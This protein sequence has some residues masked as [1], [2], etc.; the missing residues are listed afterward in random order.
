M[1]IEPALHRSIASIS[2]GEYISSSRCAFRLPNPCS[3]DH[4]ASEPN[5]LARQFQH[6]FL[7]SLEFG[8]GRRQNVHV[9]VRIADVPEDYVA[10]GEFPLPA[11]GD[12]SAS[13]SRLRATGTA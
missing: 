3:A 9:N 6:Q 5:G 13:I 1:R 2:A 8:G 4:R 11:P 10:A 7:T 12:R